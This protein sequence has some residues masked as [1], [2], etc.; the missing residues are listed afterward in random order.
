MLQ[1]GSIA[2]RAASKAAAEWACG[3]FKV[4]DAQ[5]FEGF[6]TV[7]V[8]HH[9]CSLAT[10]AQASNACNATSAGCSNLAAILSGALV[11]VICMCCINPLN[12]FF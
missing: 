6:R 8:V 2:A 12:L 9:N 7:S 10:T 1:G 4:H 5:S 11:E 3:N